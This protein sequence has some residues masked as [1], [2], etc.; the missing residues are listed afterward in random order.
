M[1][2]LFVI[3]KLVLADSIEKAIKKE[4]EFPVTTA[5]LDPEWKKT[6][7]QYSPGGGSFKGFELK[8]KKK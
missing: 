8:L 3:E 6:H 2:K 1:K 7:L 5:Y 4:K